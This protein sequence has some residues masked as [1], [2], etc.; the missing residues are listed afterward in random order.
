MQAL[1][2]D[3]KLSLKNDGRL[4]IAFIGTGSA[5]AKTLFQTN[6]LIIKGGTHIMVD[7]GMTGPRALMVHAGLDV[8]DLEVFLPT[9]SHAD[10][11]GGLEATALMNRYVGRKFMGKPKLKAIISEPYQEV[12]WDRTL[13]GGME[14][15]EETDDKKRLCFTDFFDVIRPR[16]LTQQPREI[17]TVEL[18]G[19]R[20]EMFRTKHIPDTAA[21]WQASFISYG[22][23]ISLGRRDDLGIFISGDS[24]WDPELIDY[25]APRSEFLFHDVQFFPG[26]VHA[27]LADLK[28]LRADVKE[29]TALVHYADN[30]PQQDISGFAGWAK[31][32]HRY[33]FD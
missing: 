30:W 23:F 14:W 27:P 1:P 26:A 22:L 21:D 20:M 32:G 11:V 25:Y 31:E 15:N 13:R 2:I 17:W 28:N 9:H 8:T 6:F 29:R 19:I 16:W 10:H 12:L 4:E 5:F 18:G 33:I 7:F 3:K 24:R